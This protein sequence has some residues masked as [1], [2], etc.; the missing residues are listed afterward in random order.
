M[1]PSTEFGWV[2]MKGST[3]VVGAP[4]EMPSPE[5]GSEGIGVVRLYSLSG[6]IPAPA[7]YYAPLAPAS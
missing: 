5:V 7:D 4:E 6:S 3:L 1:W 2:A